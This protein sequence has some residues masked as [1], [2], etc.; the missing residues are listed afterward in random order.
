MGQN[1]AKSKKYCTLE[2]NKGM[3]RGLINI[4]LRFADWKYL[5][6]RR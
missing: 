4:L 2:G 5:Q 3:G 6:E 1:I